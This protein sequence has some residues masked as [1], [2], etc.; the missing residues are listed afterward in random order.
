MDEFLIKDIKLYGKHGCFAKELKEP[1]L[2]KVSMRIFLDLKKAA[3]SD[4]LCDTVDYPAAIKV[5]ETVITGESVRLI[6]KLAELIAR[7][8]LVEFKMIE[9]INVKVVKCNTSYVSSV[10]AVAAKVK[11]TRKDFE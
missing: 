7:K 11:R 9:K 4:E 8:M 1:T 3:K 5:A 6:E 2:F 10:G